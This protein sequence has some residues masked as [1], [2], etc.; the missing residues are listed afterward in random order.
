MYNLR[1]DKQQKEDQLVQHTKRITFNKSQQ[2]L[3]LH[4]LS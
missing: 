4:S 2:V 3:R 1:V